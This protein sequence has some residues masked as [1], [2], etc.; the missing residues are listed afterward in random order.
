MQKLSS[1]NFYLFCKL[2]DLTIVVKYEV[3]YFFSFSKSK[4]QESKQYKNINSSIG[5][6]TIELYAVK[7]EKRYCDEK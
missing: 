5:S 2:K 1:F 7:K 3:I 6:I 4:D